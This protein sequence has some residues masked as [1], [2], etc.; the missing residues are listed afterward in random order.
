MEGPNDLRDAITK[1]KVST[2]HFSAAGDNKRKGIT[3]F[4]QSYDNDCLTPV[5]LED[6]AVPAGTTSGRYRS[7]VAG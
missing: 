2:F 7:P 1:G 4:G 6:G 5:S 3:P